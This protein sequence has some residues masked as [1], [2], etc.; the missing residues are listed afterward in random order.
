ME[1]LSVKRDQ[2]VVRD[3]AH[4]YKAAIVTVVDQGET[5][6]F[7]ISEEIIAL[8]KDPDSYIRGECEA[9]LYLHRKASQ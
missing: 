6:T 1:I 3:L 8:V 4:S 7:W 5:F 9:L 2:L